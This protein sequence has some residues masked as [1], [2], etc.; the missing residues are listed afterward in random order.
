MG[1]EMKMIS[2]DY[3][4]IDSVYQPDEVIEIIKRNTDATSVI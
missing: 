2:S 4:V 1:K 3:F